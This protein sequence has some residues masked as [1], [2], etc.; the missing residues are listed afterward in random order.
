MARATTRCYALSIEGLHNVTVQPL[1][2][3]FT[4]PPLS[5]LSLFCCQ[6][7]SSHVPPL[8]PTALL[9]DDPS[10]LHFSSGRHH[11]LIL[12][13]A[14]AVAWGSQYECGTVLINA[15]K[16][17]MPT[18]DQVWP[19]AR[20]HLCGTKYG[21]C[22]HIQSRRGCNGDERTAVASVSVPPWEDL[23]F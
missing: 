6:L 12:T 5:H 3:P 17:G 8:L 13:L 16:E 9:H 18:R 2:Y 7:A 15:L 22:L 4:T 10:S 11:V 20:V 1:V 23:N 19:I 21:W 14:S